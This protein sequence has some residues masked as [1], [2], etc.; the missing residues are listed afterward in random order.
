MKKMTQFTLGIAT[1]F[2]IVGLVAIIAVWA[3]ADWKFSMITSA[4]FETTTHEEL[5][6]FENIKIN[7]DTADITIL[8][9]T[10]GKSKV[11]TFEHKD[12]K[13]EVS[14]ADGTL[15]I[16][17]N[18]RRGP[19]RFINI[20]A[21]PEITIYLTEK[22]YKNL[23][24]DESTGDIEMEHAFT[25]ADV[26][27]RLSTGD[28][29]F[30]NLTCQS[31]K[32]NGSTGDTALDNLKVLGDAYI[33]RSTGDIELDE[34]TVGGK[35]EVHVSTGCV[36]IE[37]IT[38]ATLK[39][40]GNTGEMW[41][42][43]ATVTDDLEIN[44]STGKVE[45]AGVVAKN[46]T[47]EA[48]TGDLVLVDVVLSGTLNATRSTGDVKFAGSDAAEIYVTTDTGSVTGNLLTDKVFIVRSD[49]GKI[50]VPKTITGGRCEIKTDTGRIVITVGK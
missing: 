3:K 2:I 18:D 7:S 45:L 31:L 25:F 19:G 41:L 11:V 23:T 48:D 12:A 38:T 9:S 27:I 17:L 15:S 5:S 10:D 22:E 30:E 24:V 46:L 42:A 13:H 33:K 14:S 40:T 37:K 29:D 39:S 35:T 26:D 32:I 34:I 8:P 28:V 6:D 4:N 20:S 47:S 50:D 44:R 36:E 49:T 43:D 21:N 16:T 1:G